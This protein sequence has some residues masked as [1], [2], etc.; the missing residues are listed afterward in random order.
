[1]KK[2]GV[3]VV[4]LLIVIF[5]SVIVNRVYK[6]Q[7]KET[8][9]GAAQYDIITYKPDVSLQ[10]NITDHPMRAQIL[11]TYSTVSPP[12]PAKADID[13]M[14]KKLDDWYT[15][16]ISNGSS[17]PMDKWAKISIDAALDSISMG[18][19]AIGNVIC[20]MPKGTENSPEKWIEILRGGNRLFARNPSDLL[21]TTGAVPKF[22]SHA[23]G[24][25]TVLDAFEDRLS[26]GFYDKSSPNYAF[27]KRTPIDFRVRSK[28][29]GY[30]M[31]DGIVLFTQLNS[32]Q[33]CLSRIGNS[34][35]A[36][37]YW[38]AP[39]TAGGMAHRLCDSVPAYFNML[40]RQLHAVADVS[41]ALIQFAFDAFAGPE[42][43]WVNYC[44]WKLQQ[45]GSPQNL[46]ADY[47]YCKGQYYAND[48]V[49]QNSMY[50]WGGFFRTFNHDGGPTLE[51]KVSPPPQ[52]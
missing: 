46:V 49:G 15:G 30:G 38:V 4:I 44:T 50:D 41:P 8:Y 25:M 11:Q 17:R 52:P 14:R 19:W 6:G 18:N 12:A 22:D 39:D 45:I 9:S 37:C 28:E 34:G 29:L 2:G 20:Y 5:T 48:A 10:Y 23:H 1:M 51:C 31:P 7:K 33:M 3:I 24:E 16:S 21:A 42:G 43:K 36:R 13:L 26:R 47:G 32:C 40:N 35:I 27:D